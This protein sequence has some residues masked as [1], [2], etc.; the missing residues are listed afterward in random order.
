MNSQEI[1]QRAREELT[2]ELV[3][4]KVE[5]LKK[6]LRRPWWVR[7]FPWRVKILLIRR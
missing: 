4:E 1:Q 3:R 7:L 5:E 2:R 6:R